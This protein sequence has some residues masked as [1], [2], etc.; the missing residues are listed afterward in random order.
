MRD[1]DIYR[2][3][4][5]AERS[6]SPKKT[7]KN[8]QNMFYKI[9]SFQVACSTQWNMGDFTGM[10]QKSRLIKTLMVTSN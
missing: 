10:E 1:T 5:L 8:P 7:Q 6:G 4:E 9:D 3:V 2:V